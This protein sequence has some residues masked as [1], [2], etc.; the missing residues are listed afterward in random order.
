MSLTDI[1]IAGYRSVRNITFPVKKLSVLVGGNGI[2]KTNL[3][4]SLQ[5]LHAAATG[6]L[7]E[8]L[9]RDGGLASL[10]WAGERRRN[11]QPKLELS[12]TFDS[13]GEA[14]DL[15]P[16]YDLEIGFPPS[17]TLEVGFPIPTAAAFPLEA[18]VKSETLTV[19][20]SGR[21]VMLMERS[22]PSVWA[23]DG[24]GKRVLVQDNLLASET[25]LSS[26]RGGFP[27]I[28]TVRDALSAWRFYHGFRTDPE[29]PLRRHALAVTAP[30]LHPDGSN[31]AAVFATL[32]HIRQDSV[33]LDEAIAF[34]FPDA[35]LAVPMP[36]EHAEFSMIFPNLPQRAFAAREL[37]DGTLHFLALMGALLSYRLPPFIA[38]NE[39]ETSLHPDLLPALAKIIAKA[40]MRTQV[41]VVT[42]SRPLADALAEQTGILA[43]EVVRKDGGTW[44]EGLN[45]LGMFDDEE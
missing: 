9:A 42:H 8:E 20:Q 15:A 7:A 13:L 45:L 18:Q 14:T 33:D 36:G 40:A 37:S 29:S 30:L 34:A 11:E 27:E 28:D 38:L 17:Y 19:R 23:R 10:F 26:L 21:K 4:R 43:R 16:R 41:W 44:L 3:Y 39:P 2:G 25:A 5:L 1:H 22:G 12:A 31:L 35:E 24:N 6:Q 32:R